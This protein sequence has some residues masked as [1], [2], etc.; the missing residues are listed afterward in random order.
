MKNTNNFQLREG[1]HH[2]QP[3]NQHF[4]LSG[5]MTQRRALVTSLRMHKCGMS[6][7]PLGS[8]RH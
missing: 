2:M 1:S 8:K 6:K 3:P 4:S 5:N 7:E